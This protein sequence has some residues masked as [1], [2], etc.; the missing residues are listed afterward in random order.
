MI[1]VWNGYIY[2]VAYSVHAFNV[3]Y[4][5]HKFNDIYHMQIAH[6]HRR[7]WNISHFTAFKTWLYQ[8]YIEFKMNM[9]VVNY[10]SKI[11]CVGICGKCSVGQK[12]CQHE[13]TCNHGELLICVTYNTRIVT[14]VLGNGINCFVSKLWFRI[15]INLSTIK[16]Q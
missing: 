5:L 10:R 6:F 15:Y 12:W 7:Q 9:Y 8:T 4:D 11:N 16:A 1:C 14:S 13:S 3:Q 2:K